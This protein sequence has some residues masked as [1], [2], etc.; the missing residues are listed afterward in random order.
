MHRA[1]GPWGCRQNNQHLWTWS[2]H[3]DAKPFRQ[4]GKSESPMPSSRALRAEG[5]VLWNT[6]LPNTESRSLTQCPSEA[7]S[8]VGSHGFSKPHG[9]M[10]RENSENKLTI[11][12][13]ERKHQAAPQF[14]FRMSVMGGLS[15]HKTA[16]QLSVWSVAS[17]ESSGRVLGACA[18]RA[19][20]LSNCQRPVC[21]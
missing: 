13:K 11:I 15:G 4:K 3:P 9:L 19:G 1:S 5:L 6:R 8:P 16:V 10:K 2:P 7:L 21:S 18:A 17:P 14:P 20:P 12:K